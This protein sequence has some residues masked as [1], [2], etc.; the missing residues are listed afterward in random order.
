[1]N[2]NA[3]LKQAQAMQKDMLK[4]KEEIDNKIFTASNGFVSVTMKGSKELTYVKI[5]QEQLE[6][7]DIE[8]LQDMILVAVNDAIKQIDK[9]TESKLGRYTKGMPGLF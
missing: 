7:D 2:M 8:M 6:K 4:A 3:L 1:M 5:D 9:E